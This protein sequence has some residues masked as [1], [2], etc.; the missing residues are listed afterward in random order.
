MFHITAR[1]VALALALAAAAA[2]AVRADNLDDRL[3]RATPEIVHKLHDEGHKNVGV[4]HFRVE[5]G[6]NVGA[7]AAF[8]LGTIAES[9]AERVEN[10]LVLCDKDSLNVIHDASATAAAAKVGAWFRE[11][12]QR[13]KLFKP[14]YPLAWGKQK[15]EADAF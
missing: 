8:S 12:G 9:L 13:P 11:P 6:K 7:K 10:A 2:P 5:K 3:L 1:R 15:V 4:L 14:Q